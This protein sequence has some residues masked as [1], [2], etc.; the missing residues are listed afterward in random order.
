MVA[1][2][3]LDDG[4][5][6]SQR[7]IPRCLKKLATKRGTRLSCLGGFSDVAALSAQECATFPAHA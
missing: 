2:A 1:V 6:A 7:I 4:S 3:N 5:S